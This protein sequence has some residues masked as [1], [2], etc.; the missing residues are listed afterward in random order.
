M[1]HHIKFG[2]I[3]YDDSDFQEAWFRY[4]HQSYRYC[5]PTFLKDNSP[6]FLLRSNIARE[7]LS[8]CI[9]S[10]PETKHSSSSN[11]T[12]R[13]AQQTN[14]VN[15]VLT[16]ETPIRTWFSRSST[17]VFSLGKECLLT[18]HSATLQNGIRRKFA[19]SFT[20]VL[21]LPSRPFSVS[22]RLSGKGIDMWS[23]PK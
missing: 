3:R 1:F 19:A 7:I 4:A 8:R 14:A 5:R 12:C 15:N 16:A 20:H 6:A 9:M 17:L 21:Q 11:S 22:A 13:A 23:S 2:N 10:D 18:A